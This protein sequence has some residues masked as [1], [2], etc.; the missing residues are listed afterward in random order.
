MAHHN[1]ITVLA[2]ATVANVVC[3]FDILGFAIEQPNDE[4]TLRR[5]EHYSEI[6]IQ[7]VDGFGL[8]NDPSVNICGIALKAFQDAFEE[9]VGF[10]L[11]CNKTIKPG[12]GI[13]SSAASAA[14]VVVAANLLFGEPFSK[15]QL[16]EFAMAGEAVAS[17]ARHAD[18]IAP[19]ILGG[20]TLVRS[21]DPLDIIQLNYPHLYVVVLHPQIEVRTADARAV[22]PKEI[23][24]ST[25]VKQWAN[26]ATVIA[27]LEQ[28]N[29]DILQRGLVDII[30]EPARSVL[31][32]GFNETKAAALS[33]GA[34]G[35]GISGS[36][37]SMFM[38]CTDQASAEAVEKA[39]S[40]SYQKTKIAFHTHIS[41][42]NPHGVRI[43]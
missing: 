17:G 24:L 38:F 6:T 36:G 41:T 22:L 27:G 43:K 31:I 37:P 10:E 30:V 3:G 2:P 34:L 16:I 9:P 42:I 29:I 25:A 20:F 11:I 8:P 32:P 28:K 23:A 19:C 18:N 13:G 7:S 15:M 4:F 39:M 12:S 35:G 33:A 26:V 40:T 5:I 21:N 1:E 14:G